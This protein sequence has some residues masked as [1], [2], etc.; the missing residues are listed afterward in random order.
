M[1][2]YFFKFREIAVKLRVYMLRTGSYI[3]LINTSMILFLFLSNLE[4]YGIDIEIQDWIVPLFFIGL[5]SMFLFGYLEDKLG[6]YTQEQKT[7]QS[8]SPYF[9][10]IIDRLDKI[11]KQL[12]KKK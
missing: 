12:E 2:K 10:E 11:E 3:S 1:K 6:F 9:K 5:L 4:Q 8:K 7:T